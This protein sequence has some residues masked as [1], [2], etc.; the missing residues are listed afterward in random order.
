MH[1]DSEED[2]RNPTGSVFC[3]HGSGYVVPWDE[4]PEHMHLPYVYHGD[5]SEEALAA[6][7]R[8]QNAFSAEDAQALAGNRRRTSFEKAVSVCHQ[9]SLMR[10]LQ[11]FMP[12]SL[13]WAKTISQRIRGANGR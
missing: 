13:A 11:M 4:V 3:A 6:S 5:E 1:Y 2:F 12:G 9:W 8:T 7:A 10:S